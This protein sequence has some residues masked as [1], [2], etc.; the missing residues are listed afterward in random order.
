MMPLPHQSTSKTRTNV[1]V[2]RKIPVSLA[3]VLMPPES[4]A[5]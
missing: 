5:D 3:I 2:S 1:K 4:K